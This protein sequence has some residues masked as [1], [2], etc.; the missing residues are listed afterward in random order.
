MG[1]ILLF[2][3]IVSLVLV[4]NLATRMRDERISKLFFTF[5]FLINI[6]TFILG[7]LFVILPEWRLQTFQSNGVLNLTDPITYGIIL[8]LTAVWGVIVTV[9]QTRHALLRN[10]R[11]SFQSPIHGLALLGA[12]YLVGNVALILSQGSLEQLAET[13][14]PATLLDILTPGIAFSLLGFIG[15]GLIIRRSYPDTI[16]R[17]GLVRPTRTS[18]FISFR[19]IIGLVIL[20]GFVGVLWGTFFPTEAEQLTTINE[21][22]LEN[23]DT[24]CECNPKLNRG[25]R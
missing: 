23:V 15:V 14:E 1:L 10:T 19:W 13:A 20:Q 25:R 17:L 8:Q 24:V 2:F 16:K 22:L 18:F 6:P 4:A 21:R 11:F 12:G 5:L 9:G 7:V 3:F